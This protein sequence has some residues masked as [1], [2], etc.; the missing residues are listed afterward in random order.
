MPLMDLLN[1]L[2]ISRRY[3]ATW[4]AKESEKLSRKIFRWGEANGKWHRGH[5]SNKIYREI[6]GKE[7]GSVLKKG[8]I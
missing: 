4:F 3:K 6:G 7:C 1:S 8:G 5:A 2:S